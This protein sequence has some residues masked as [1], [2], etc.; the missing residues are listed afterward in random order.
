MI[1]LRVMLVLETMR[2][3]IPN[4]GSPLRALVQCPRCEDETLLDLG[5]ITSHATRLHCL[6]RPGDLLRCE[7]CDGR[8]VRRPAAL[9][10]ESDPGNRSAMIVDM[11][12]RRPGIA[13]PEPISRPARRTRR[14]N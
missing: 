14:Q 1:S 6:T 11:D 5:E 10:P 13:T 3:F 9:R 12:A 8:L 2:D 4:R 7:K